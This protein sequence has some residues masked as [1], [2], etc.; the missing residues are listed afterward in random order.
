MSSSMRVM[1]KTTPRAVLGTR[2][3][4]L[5]VGIAAAVVIIVLAPVGLGVVLGPS[6]VAAGLMLGTAIGEVAVRGPA[7]DG[8]K[9]N[10]GP[11]AL[12]SAI[13]RNLTVAVGIAVLLFAG[14]LAATTA[15]AAS[16]AHP[17][18]SRTVQV[19]CTSGQLATAT[20][21]PGSYFSVPL[22]II[23]GCGVVI[24]A[25]AVILVVRRPRGATV[26]DGVDL[27]RV[28]RANAR[29]I[30]EGIAGLLGVAFGSAVLAAGTAL[31]N[32]GCGSTTHRIVGWVLLILAIIAM[33]GALRYV[34]RLLFGPSGRQPRHGA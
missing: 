14:T 2:L 16:D 4:G 29:P 32:I 24:A 13:P 3:G 10:A 1:P 26:S 22:G 20:P 19:V 21:W 23:V 12:W 11:R 25:A 30:V 6:L 5:V 9:E 18:G 27:A 28:R 17:G 34:A 8:E 15:T 31:V 7:W 33:L